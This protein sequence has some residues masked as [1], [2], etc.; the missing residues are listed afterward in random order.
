MSGWAA[1][2]WAPD[3]APVGRWE[4][5]DYWPVG[6]HSIVRMS[7]SELEALELV[8]VRVEDTSHRARR[9]HPADC[10]HP[11]KQGLRADP[12]RAT[13]GRLDIGRDA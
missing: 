4:M 11:H 2:L 5:A 7:S 3:T 1:V 13:I 8:A 10:R 12:G 6:R 9:V